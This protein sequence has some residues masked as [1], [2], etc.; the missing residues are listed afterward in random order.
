MAW[1]VNCVRR[2]VTGS[3]LRSMM[4]RSGFPPPLL[5]VKSWDSVVMA[6]LNSLAREAHASL[7]AR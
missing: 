2:G 5:K 7:L 1:Y 4:I 3:S 6:E